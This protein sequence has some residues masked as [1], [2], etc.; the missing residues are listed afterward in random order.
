MSANTPPPDAA[1]CPLCARPNRCAMEIE[2]ETGQPQPPCW[3]TQVDFSGD[4]LE[5]V[6]A[7]ARG[8]ACICAACAA[9]GR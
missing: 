7:E 8:Q 5:Q 3:C 6:P 1:L 4:L 9:R 2:R